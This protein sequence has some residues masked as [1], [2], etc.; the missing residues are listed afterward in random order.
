MFTIISIIAVAVWIL[1]AF[2]EWKKKGMASILKHNIWL[3]L[4]VVCGIIPQFV[5]YARSTMYGRYILPLTILWG[6]YFILPA[7]KAAG[8]LKRKGYSSLLSFT[9]CFMLFWGL[10]NSYDGAKQWGEFGYGTKATVELARNKYQLN[11]STGA[12][13]LHIN[14]SEYDKGVETWLNLNAKDVDV[15]NYRDAVSGDDYPVIVTCISNFASDT[16][17]NEII[18]GKAEYDYDVIYS[19]FVVM[20]RKQ[21]E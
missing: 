18:G 2:G 19:N 1:Y 16:E 17:F 5:L 12:L 4:A 6:G 13:L 11:G 9:L 21:Y 14:D 7:L 8:Q 10:F 15:V 3:A 20:W